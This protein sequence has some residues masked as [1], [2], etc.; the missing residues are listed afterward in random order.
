MV[1]NTCGGS[2]HKSQAR[3]FVN[4]SN[5]RSHLRTAEE[6]EEY[7]KVL[8]LCGSGICQIET[9]G[10]KQYNC[11]IRGKFKSRN[12]KDN[13]VLKGGIVLVGLRDFESQEE[14]KVGGKIKLPNCDLLEVYNSSEINRLK[15]TVNID[16]KNLV[17]EE[18]D[19]IK[20]IDTDYVDFVQND[21]VDEYE[22]IMNSTLANN[23][24]NMIKLEEEE[25]NV[26]DI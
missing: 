19:S 26:D 4:P 7:A 6:G 17:K 21:D 9:V 22:A 18:L 14:K 25:I 13:T 15:Q 16:W 11:H 3:K 10:G 23:D 20:K 8:Q 2:K 24:S 1:K 5:V 12:K